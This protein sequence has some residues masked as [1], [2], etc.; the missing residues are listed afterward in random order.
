[1]GALFQA[2]ARSPNGEKSGVEPAERGSKLT[3]AKRAGASKARGVGKGQGGPAELLA[4]ERDPAGETLLW[5]ESLKA[6]DQ[7][8]FFG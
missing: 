1:M 2:T 8:M 4:Q 7:D 5:G 6:T 3:F